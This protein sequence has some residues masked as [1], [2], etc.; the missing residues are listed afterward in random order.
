MNLE[1]N[2]LHLYSAAKIGMKFCMALRETVTEL[3]FI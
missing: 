1:L 2:F 3:F